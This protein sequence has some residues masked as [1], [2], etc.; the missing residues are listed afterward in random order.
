M[1]VVS[2]VELQAVTP[3]TF[4]YKALKPIPCVII[5][6]RLTDLSHDEKPHLRA[7]SRDYVLHNLG[8]CLGD[9]ATRYGRGMSNLELH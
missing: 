9:P 2:H 1:G 8:L 7:H 6:S 3:V 5:E 4:V